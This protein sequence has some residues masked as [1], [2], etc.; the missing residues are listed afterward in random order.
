MSGQ[1]RRAHSE[2]RRNTAL[3]PYL[4]ALMCGL[5]VATFLFLIHQFS[6]LYGCGFDCLCG[7]II[8]G[9]LICRYERSRSKYLTVRL[10]SIKLMNHHVR[11]ALNVIM[12]SVHKHGHVEVLN[13]IQSSINRIDWALREILPGRVLDDDDYDG[14]AAEQEQ[15]QERVA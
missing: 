8:V 7:G 1:S 13:E 10:K 5:V 11:N 2:A 6:K 12:L 9:L 14:T 4:L 3:R 15:E